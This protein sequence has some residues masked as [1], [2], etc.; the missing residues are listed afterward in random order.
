MKKLSIL[1][2]TLFA[3]TVFTTLSY[4]QEKPVSPRVT[5][6]GK[7][8]E[9]AYGQPSKKGRVVFGELE[10]YG[11]VWRTGANKSTEITFA[12]DTDFGGKQVKAGSYSLF[13]IPQ[14]KE[15]TVILSSRLGQSGAFEYK[16]SEDVLR[17]KAPVKKLNTLV[18]KLT[19]KIDDKSNGGDLTI[20]WDQTSVTVPM[21]F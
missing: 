18:E 13:T 12:K 2:L 6:K 1:L 10:P 19:F 3:A 8:V 14:E 11:K 4:G 9:V 7:S 16:D 5:T 17:V 20:M 15:W 21:K